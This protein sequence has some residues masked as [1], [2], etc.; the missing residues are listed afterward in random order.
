M[1]LHSGFLST[2][3]QSRKNDMTDTPDEKTEPLGYEIH[4]LREENERLR[5]ERDQW[6]G[7]ADRLIGNAQG[8]TYGCP[9]QWRRILDADIAAYK[10]AKGM[11]P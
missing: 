10:E 7:I 4:R 11:A 8:P 3:L 2:W 1:S 5:A 6:R 9:W